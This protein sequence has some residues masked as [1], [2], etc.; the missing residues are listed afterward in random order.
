MRPALLFLPIK[1]ACLPACLHACV[2]ACLPACLPAPSGWLVCPLPACPPN[3]GFPLRKELT[4]FAPKLVLQA[5]MEGL[6]CGLPCFSFPSKL[7]A[8]LPAQSFFQLSWLALQKARREVGAR[9]DDRAQIFSA[10]PLLWL[11]PQSDHGSA[12]CAETEAFFQHGPLQSFFEFNSTG[13]P[14]KKHARA[15]LWLAPQSDH[16]SAARAEAEAVFQYGPPQSDCGGGRLKR[17]STL[18]K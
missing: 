2:P 9:T 5:R 14:Y 12:A 7:P 13:S 1:A 17:P 6:R 4:S 3:N 16:G 11:A 8:C 15:L 10:A 18:I